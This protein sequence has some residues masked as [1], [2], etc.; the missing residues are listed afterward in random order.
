MKKIF[1]ACVTALLVFFCQG[2]TAAPPDCPAVEIVRYKWRPTDD[3]GNKAASRGELVFCDDEILL[4]AKV[5]DTEVRLR[6]EYLI[7]DDTITVMSE[8]YGTV[9]M[10]YD[11]SSEYL[12]LTYFGKSARFVKDTA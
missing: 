2:C 12:T 10:G 1:F 8:Q 6:G 9:C 11:L 5:S 3:S 4:A 7:D